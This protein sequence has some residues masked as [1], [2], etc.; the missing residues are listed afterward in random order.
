MGVL[1]LRATE[2]LSDRVFQPLAVVLCDRGQRLQSRYE[3]GQVERTN[4]FGDARER[5]RDPVPMLSAAECVAPSGEPRRAAGFLAAV[6]LAA[7]APLGCLLFLPLL[8]RRR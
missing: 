4:E 1:Y 3:W 6:W 2:R 8:R 7:A 5:M